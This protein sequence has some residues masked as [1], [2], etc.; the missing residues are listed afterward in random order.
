[1]L[2]QLTALPNSTSEIPT[3]R[4]H[5]AVN[6]HRT[7][8]PGPVITGVPL[9]RQQPNRCFERLTVLAVRFGSPDSAVQSLKLR[10]KTRP[11]VTVVRMWV[12]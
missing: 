3:C 9:S 4:V 2:A 6:A 1:V 12:R 5:D 7:C 10:H 8:R 11:K